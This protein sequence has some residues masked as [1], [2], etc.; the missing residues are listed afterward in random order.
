MSQ[1]MRGSKIMSKIMN[2]HLVAGLGLV[3][4]LAGPAHAA[5]MGVLHKAPVVMQ[6][7]WTGF[8]LGINGGYGSARS[9]HDVPGANLGTLDQKGWVAGGVA[10]YNWRT[11][12]VMLGVELDISSA[13]LQGSTSAGLCGAIVPAG[14][15]TK[16]AWFYTGRA[17]LGAPIGPIMPYLT[18]GA[19]GG[20]LEV[21][22]SG[23]GSDANPNLWGW[24][25]GGGLEVMIL[26]QWTIRAEFLH[27]ELFGHMDATDIN[28]AFNFG[29][30][31]TITE[32]NINI[33][34]IGLTY[35]LGADRGIVSA[36]S[37]K[38]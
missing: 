20:G 34:R 17:R 1:Q 15:E 19:I 14:C 25:G 8:Y 28:G 7:P 2:N 30:P 36:V 33:G 35:Y 24:V 4:L 10:G 27:A 32:R 38:Y 9:S 37:S 26:P 11:G 29:P 12:P 6:D 22:E 13:N 3:A 23:A 21:A 31:V 16:L 18:A 5:D